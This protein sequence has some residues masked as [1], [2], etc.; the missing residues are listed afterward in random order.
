MMY[1]GTLKHQTGAGLVYEKFYYDGPITL[2]IGK[3]IENLYAAFYLRFLLLQD[4]AI[5]ELGTLL[6]RTQFII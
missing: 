6:S 2:P 3:Q 5:T 1:Q 4:Q